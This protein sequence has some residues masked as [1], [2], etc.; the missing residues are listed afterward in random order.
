MTVRTGGA[1]GGGN[2]PPPNILPT[3]KKLELKNKDI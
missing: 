1:G 3:K 2:C